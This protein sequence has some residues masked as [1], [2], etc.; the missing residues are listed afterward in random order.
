MITIVIGGRKVQV[1]EGFLVSQV[2]GWLEF[3]IEMVKE[4]RAN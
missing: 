3:T 1:R 2:K 4:L